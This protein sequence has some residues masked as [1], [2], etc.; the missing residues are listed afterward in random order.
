MPR[1]AVQ[2]RL[3]PPSLDGLSL[4]FS[5]SAKPG[6][7]SGCPP[8]PVLSKFRGDDACS[9]NSSKSLS[10][11]A[12]CRPLGP[13]SVA[14]R[15]AARAVAVQIA[16]DQKPNL[17]KLAAC[18]ARSRGCARSTPTSGS[19]PLCELCDLRVL[20]VKL[21]LFRSFLTLES[22]FKQGIL[23][24]LSVH[25]VSSAQNPFFLS[26]AQFLP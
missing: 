25:S 18:R 6:P 16:P 11:L 17:D 15:M 7:N 1:K 5:A 12:F 9:N 20:C 3:K 26:F 4:L 2:I 21:F 10:E 23:S 24:V 19:F 14:D 13:T 22:R 8:V